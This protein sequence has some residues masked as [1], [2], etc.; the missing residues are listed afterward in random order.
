MQV[1]TS[2]RNCRRAP[3]CLLDTPTWTSKSYCKPPTA[4]RALGSSGPRLGFPEFPGF[5]HSSHLLQPRLVPLTPCPALP[6][7][8][9]LLC[10]ST[11]PAGSC[12]RA[13]APPVLSSWTAFPST[14]A[15]PALLPPGRPRFKQ[16]LLRR[17]F[18]TIQT[19]TLLWRS[20]PTSL[21]QFPAQHLLVAGIFLTFTYLSNKY[22]QSPNYVPG[23]DLDGDTAMNKNQLPS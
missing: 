13:F 10:P 7:N 17:G 9:S 2:F 14:F 19:R 5:L 20:A 15:R 18:L 16:H 12:L 8:F 21:F 6:G 3:S 23:T 4:R 22:L 1:L 11:S